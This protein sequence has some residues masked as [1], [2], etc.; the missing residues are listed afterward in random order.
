[1]LRQD[2]TT[3]LDVAF[4]DVGFDDDWDAPLGCTVGMFGRNLGWVMCWFFPIFFKRNIP[5]KQKGCFLM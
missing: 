5:P 2:R 1:M 3:P 4:H